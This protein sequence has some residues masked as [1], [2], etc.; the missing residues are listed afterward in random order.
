[1]SNHGTDPRTRMRLMRERVEAMKEIWAH[2]EA[3]Y[4]GEF[5]EFERI[6][7]GRSRLS[8]PIHRCSS[9]APDRP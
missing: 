1:M 9:A 2:D 4:K 3:S 6:G 7:P 8:A 5:V